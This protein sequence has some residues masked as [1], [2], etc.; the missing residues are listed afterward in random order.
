MHDNEFILHLMTAIRKRKNRMVIVVS[1][2]IIKGKISGQGKMHYKIEPTY[3][4]DKGFC[5]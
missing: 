2:D 4:V 5:S 1:F 3:N